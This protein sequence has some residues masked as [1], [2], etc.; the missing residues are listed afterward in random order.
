[1]HYCQLI[2][3]EYTEHLA[4][5]EHTLVLM[6]QAVFTLLL[7]NA[8][9]EDHAATGMRGEMKLFQRFKLLIDKHLHQH[10]TVTD[11]ACELHI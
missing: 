2:E 8:K 9:L 7:R 4:G 5:C 6:A 11:Y 3:R 1:K 10:W